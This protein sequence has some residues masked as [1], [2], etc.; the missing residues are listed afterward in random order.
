[1]TRVIR[2]TPTCATCR[3]EHTCTLSLVFLVWSLIT[4]HM[5]QGRSRVCHP[6]S[7]PSM[8]CGCLWVSPLHLLLLHAFLLPLPVLLL[9]VRLRLWLRDK[10][11]AWLR[12]RDLRHPGRFLPSH[13]VQ[14][15]TIAV[16]DTIWISVQKTT[17]PNRSPRSS[18]QQSVRNA[19]RTPS[20]RGK[21]PVVKRLDG[22]A[23]I[24]SK[25]L[26]PLHSVKSG[27]L[28]SAGSTSPQSVCRFG[29]SAIIRIAR[30]M[31]TPATDTGKLQKRKNIIWPITWK[32]D[33]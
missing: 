16:S 25:E 24:T 18:T 20:P 15:E 32:R 21:V 9:D 3:I 4:L 27:I 1:M 5:A 6:I 10:Q 13:S 17:Q 30:L 33:A 31:N 19:S 22:P 26:A 29:E 12:Q 7:I 14:K 2:R 11:P 23:R 28:Q 8:M